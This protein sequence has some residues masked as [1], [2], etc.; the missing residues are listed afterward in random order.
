MRQKILLRFMKQQSRRFYILFFLWFVVFS[1]AG[2]QENSNK[3]RLVDI[4]QSLQD[5][6]AIQFNYAED[7][8]KDILLLPPKTS[9]TINEALEYLNTYTKLSF[10][11]TQEQFVVIEPSKGY[12]LCGYLKDKVTLEPL[13]SATIQTDNNATV[14]DENGFFKLQLTNKS[15]QVT[16]RFLGYKT[17]S[18]S[19]AEVAGINCETVFMEPTIEALSEIV[20][21]S[22]IVDGISKINDGTFNIDLEKFN[23]LPGLIDTD[24]LQSVQAFPGIQS[25]NETVSNINIRGGTNDQNLIL[26]DGIKMYQSGHFFGLISMYNPQI[27][28]QVSLHKNGSDVKYT[29][30]VSGTIAMRTDRSVTKKFKGTIGVNLI[31]V[32]AF[33]DIP[34]GET[35]SLQIAGRKGLSDF[36]KTPVYNAFFDRIAQDTELDTNTE[37]IVN[38]DETFDFYDTSLRW[39]YDISTKDK[40]RVNFINV[41]NDLTF[42]EQSIVNTAEASRESSI[43]QNSIAG[44]LQYERQWSN[45][46]NTTFEAYETYYSLEAKNA[47]VLDDQRFLQENRVSE[48]SLKLVTDYQINAKFSLLNGYH[49]VETKVTNLDDVDVPRFRL[50]VSEVIRTHGLFSQLDFSNI[51]K[52]MR[53]NA[54]IRLNHIEKFGKTLVEP[55][56]SFNQRFLEDFTFEV[57]GEFKHQN[58]SQ[59]INFQNDFLGIEKRR[60]QL[61]NDADIP[62]ITSKQISAGLSFNRKGWLISFDSYYKRVKGITTQSQGFQNQYEFTK[63]KGRYNAKGFDVLFRKKMRHLNTWLSYA[64]MENTYEFSSLEE[65]SFPSNFNIIHAVTLG[66]AYTTKKLKLSAGFNWH[67]GNPTTNLVSGNEIIDG[68]LNFAETNRSNLRDYMRLDISAVYNFSLGTSYKAKIGASIWNLL[69]RENE[70]N[71][72]YRINNDAALETVQQSLGVTPNLSF[73]VYF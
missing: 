39:N 44:A 2:A 19:F 47:N 59:V 73:R 10:S 30:G 55:R 31:D 38:S 43:T 21:A 69:N 72:F 51:N 61:S 32:N 6:H 11:L 8:I 62:V 1:S 64:Y 70:I 58:T 35:S 46:F 52:T 26:W 67:S 5:K 36:A 68:T 54:G 14:S 71:N 60:W 18:S 3:Q 40:L 28:Q 50:L 25:N 45:T 53:L 4:L 49:F 9:F 42:N 24:V 13:V 48:T 23:I 33:V 12:I 34:I 17:Y 7:V 16:C 57:L 41:S 22:Y 15:S 29:D 20:I 65:R 66:S 37:T 63:A 27:T 56:L